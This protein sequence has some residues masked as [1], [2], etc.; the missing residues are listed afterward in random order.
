MPGTPILV[1]KLS[2]RAS[3]SAGGAAA[4][5]AAKTKNNKRANAFM[6]R[7]VCMVLGSSRTRYWL[8]FGYDY[9]EDHLGKE[10]ASALALTSYEGPRGGG[11]E[12]A[13]ETLNFVD[14]R[15]HMQA[16]RD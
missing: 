3:K 13:I 16:I 4:S 9:L 5:G 12:Y 7:G 1:R 6:P 15:R 8:G 11:E 14:G 10:R 2:T